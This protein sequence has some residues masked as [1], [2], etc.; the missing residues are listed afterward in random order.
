M[1][2]SALEE[3][4]P[5]VRAADAHLFTARSAL[6]YETRSG[7]ELNGGRTYVAANPAYGAPVWYWLREKTAKPVHL[8]VTDPLGRVMADLKGS[9]EPGLH[10][11]VWNLRGGAGLDLL[12]GARPVPAGDYVARLL[13]GTQ[14]VGSR[15]VRVESEE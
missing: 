4:T 5:A 9:G 6:A 14:A 3:L 13:V 1:D 11:L 8:Q 7:S 2:V 15:K 10:E 12:R